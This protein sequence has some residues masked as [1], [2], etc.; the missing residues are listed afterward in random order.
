[1]TPA[2]ATVFVVDDDTSVRTALKRLIQSLG[3]KVK[4]SIRLEHF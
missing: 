2:D 4:T 1:M 3:L